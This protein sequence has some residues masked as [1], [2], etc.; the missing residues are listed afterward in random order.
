MA[1]Q[2]PPTLDQALQAYVVA[3][4]ERQRASLA[5]F[6]RTLS[7]ENQT[8]AQELLQNL[9]QISKLVGHSPSH[10]WRL[11]VTAVDE[12]FGGRPRY[13]LSRVLEYLRSSECQK[14]REELRE[15]RRK[16]AVRKEGT[17]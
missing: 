3:P 7:G 1:E 9:T 8:P 2:N 16:Q 12:G 10:L 5:A 6:L 11:G 13:R 4:P 15:V 17:R 14:R